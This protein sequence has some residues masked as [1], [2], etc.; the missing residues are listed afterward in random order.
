MDHRVAHFDARRPAVDEDAS[1]LALQHRQQQ[2]GLRLVLGVED[3]GGGE[4]AFEGGDDLERLGHVGDGDDQRGGAEDFRAQR[5]IGEEIGRRGAEQGALR[6]MRAGRLDAAC[7]GGYSA[8][9]RQRA[10]ALDI[11][12]VDARRQHVLRRAAAHRRRGRGEEGIEIRPVDGD[13]EAGIGAE[14]PGAHRQRADEGRAQRFGTRGEGGGEQHDRVDR[15]HLGI[16]RDRLGPG[17]GGAHQRHAAGARSGEADRLDAVVGDQRGACLTRG[18]EVGEHALG[19]MTQRHRALD[20]A[21]HQFAGAGMGRVTLDDNR[22]TRR[23]GGGGV[24]ARDREGEGEVAG[25]EHHDRAKRDL[26][27]AQVRARQRR[28]LGQGGIDGEAR[29]AAFTQDLREKAQLAGGAAPLALDTGAGKARL[30]YGAFDQDVADRHDLI[31]DGFEEDSAGF[32]VQFGEG[33]RGLVG[34][35]TGAFHFRQ[36]CGG[37]AWFQRRAGRGVDGGIACLRVGF[38]AA[39][40]YGAGNHC[41]IPSGQG[42]ARPFRTSIPDLPEAPRCI[43]AAGLHRRPNMNDS[44]IFQE[45]DCQWLV[46]DRGAGRA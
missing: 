40:E 23:E 28:A 1:N 7:E 24:S 5:R 14:L 46:I 12:R 38:L 21:G 32:R 8:V 15:T 4:L 41:C 20:G 33:D 34:Q 13:D 17:R 10:H 44:A 6:L 27:H 43:A 39:D 36:A 30:G 11:G 19:Q 22:T 3:Q 35:R 45:E 37:E 16:D 31:G 25:A 2:R 42:F 26:A 29:P 18:G 9:A